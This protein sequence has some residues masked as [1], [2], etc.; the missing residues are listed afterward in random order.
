[1][2]FCNPQKWNVLRVSSVYSCLYH[3]WL[4]CTYVTLTFLLGTY[5]VHTRTS[6]AWYSQQMKNFCMAIVSGLYHFIP[7]STSRCCIQL[8][9]SIGLCEIFFILCFISESYHL[10][11]FT[12]IML[13]TFPWTQD[14]KILFLVFGQ[15]S[16]CD[17]KEWDVVLKQLHWSLK[18]KPNECNLVCFFPPGI[19]VD[20]LSFISHILQCS[21]LFLVAVK[22]NFANVTVLQNFQ[23][24]FLNMVKIK[25]QE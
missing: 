3:I 18:S 13:C 6:L 2:F 10:L 1:M 22:S 12:K 5:R 4:R 9:S 7:Q 25:L 11:Q 23:V 17:M 14:T 21:D 16:C 24:F 15:N 8:N 19:N 20:D